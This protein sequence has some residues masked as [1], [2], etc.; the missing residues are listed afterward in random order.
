M[1]FSHVAW[2]RALAE[3]T[4]GLLECTAMKSWLSIVGT[5]SQSGSSDTTT[6]LGRH[7]SAEPLRERMI[8]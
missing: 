2:M 6:P 8:F 4:I 1:T 3:K 5:A 7:T